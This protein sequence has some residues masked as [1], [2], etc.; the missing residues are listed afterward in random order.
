MRRQGVLRNLQVSQIWTRNGPAMKVL[1]A[2]DAAMIRGR[3]ARMVA[4]MPGVSAVLQSEDYA[5]TIDT[6]QRERPEAVL[7][8]LFMPGGTGLDVLNYIGRVT[9]MPQVFIMT[10]WSEGTMR[11]RC[12]EAGATSFFEKGPQFLEAVDAIRVMA[13]ERCG[14]GGVSTPDVAPADL[15]GA[16]RAAPADQLAVL[17]VEDHDFQRKVLARQLLALGAT[18]VLEAGDGEQALELLRERDTGVQLILCDLD[19]PR[20]DG[21]EFMRH[22]GERGSTASLVIT[23]ASDV[24][25]LNSVQMMC[26][27]YGIRPLGV[28]E[29]P[30]D[31]ERLRALMVQSRR[32]VAAKTARPAGRLPEFSLEQIAAGLRLGQFEPFFQPKVA[33]ADGRIVGAEALARWR[34]PEHGVIAPFAFIDTL[35]QSGNIDALTFQ[36]LEQAA[37]A[38]QGWRARG[39]ALYGVGQPVAGVAGRYPAGRAYCRDGRC[40]AACRRAP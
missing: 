7:L 9:P 28:L 5:S 26:Q 38:C 31:T 18:E 20:M 21:M 2:D 39:M 15:A 29:K 17:V 36:M 11:Q 12:L 19:M 27:A 22:L 8:D 13:A 37:R 3:L 16:Q 23:S 14:R 24:A 34:H 10:A 33:L 6:L 32:P 30:L 25:L 35:E 40:A 1:I 4:G